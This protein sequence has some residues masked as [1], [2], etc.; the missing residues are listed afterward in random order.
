MARSYISNFSPFIHSYLQVKL[1]EVDVKSGE[2]DEEVLCSYR[3]KLFLYGETLLDKGNGVK[4]WKV[5]GMV[6]HV[7]YVIGSIYVY[8]F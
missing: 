3:S 5:R 2:E 4:S 8:G 6:R 1:E 7:Y